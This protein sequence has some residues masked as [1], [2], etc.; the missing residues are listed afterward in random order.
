MKDFI[1]VGLLG[2]GTVGGGVIK[3]LEKNAADIEKKVGKPIRITKVW[4]AMWR[5]AAPNMVNNTFLPIKSRIFWTTPIL[6]SW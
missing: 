1:N 4:T 5:S 2:A 6:I 3:V